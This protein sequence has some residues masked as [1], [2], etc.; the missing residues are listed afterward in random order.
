MEFHSLIEKLITLGLNGDQV[1]F[2][3]SVAKIARELDE[4]NEHDLAQHVRDHLRNMPTFALKKAKFSSY[5]SLEKGTELPF[6]SETKFNLAD[7]TFADKNNKKPILSS[8]IERNINEFITS[9]EK[10]DELR[11]HGLKVGSSMILYGP[12]GC[13]KTLAVT[14]IAEKLGLPLLTARCDALVS[15]YLGSTSKNIRMLFDYAS[16]EPCV[17]FLDELDALA[18]AR[19]DQHELGEL[20]RV[21]VALL[22]NIDQLPESTIFLAASNH[23][24]LLDSAVWRRFNYRLK[25]DLPNHDARFKLFTNLLGQYVSSCD[26]LSDAATLSE[27]LSCSFIE[28]ICERTLRNNILFNANSFDTK[29]FISAICESQGVHLDETDDP[30]QKLV[31]HLRNCDEKVFTMRK[32]ASLLELSSTKVSR[33]V[34]EKNHELTGQANKSNKSFSK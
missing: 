18:K 23:E 12:P 7:R 34:K 24:N 20:K 25:V 2:Q 16:Q 11:K 3:R 8:H 5:D 6:D 1:S 13:G 10:S 31:I 4:A 26:V 14:N 33:L 30:T 9:I 22:Q 17:L 27:G 15:S 21:V 28:Q 32:I 29:F 19:D